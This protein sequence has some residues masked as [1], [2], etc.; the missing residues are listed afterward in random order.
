VISVNWA[1]LKSDMISR[2]H[3]RFFWLSSDRFIAPF[4][5]AKNGSI[6]NGKKKYKCKCKDCGYQFV[7]NPTN[8]TLSA[9]TK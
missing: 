6:H 3:E 2:S 1:L 7:E 8:I 5:N 4:S 9:E